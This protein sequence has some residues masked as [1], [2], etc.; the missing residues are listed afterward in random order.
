MGMIHYLLPH[1]KGQGCPRYGRLQ[2][3]SEET[4][5]RLA[6]HPGQ[7]SGRRQTD[8]PRA[9]QGLRRLRRF[10][11][12]D[13]DI[14]LV[15][16]CTPKQPPRRDGRRAPRSRAEHVLIKKAIALDVWSA[17]AMLKA[18]SARAGRMLLGR[19]RSAVLSRSSPSPPT[20]FSPARRQRQKTSRHTSSRHLAA[21][22]VLRHRRRRPKTGGPAVDLH[23]HDTHFIGLLAGVPGRVFSTGVVAAEWF[24]SV[25]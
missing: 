12:A 10:L 11:V 16:I 24:G 14:D 23:I 17:D 15:D 8:G 7:I 21:G 13:P 20:P 2:P 22:L 25:S 18:A 19:S 1:F 4:R 3:R 5:R 9:R 6:R